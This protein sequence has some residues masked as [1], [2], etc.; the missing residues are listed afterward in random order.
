MG[1]WSASSSYAP[2]DAVSDGNGSAYIALDAV[3]ANGS[4][5][6][7]DPTDWSLLVQGQ[8]SSDVTWSVVA[9]TVQATTTWPGT[10]P[11]S[12]VTGT[13]QIDSNTAISSDGVTSLWVGTGGVTTQGSS[14]TGVGLDALRNDQYGYN[15]TAV[16]FRALGSLTGEPGNYTNNTAVGSNS[17]AYVTTGTYNTGLG[18]ATLLNDSTGGGNTAIGA[19]AMQTYSGTGATDG[20]IAIGYYAGSELT[21]GANNIYLGSQGPASA[22][23]ESGVTRIGTSPT[24]TTTFIAGI[25]GATVGAG[26]QAVYIDS[27]GQLG[28]QVTGGTSSLPPFVAG[29][30][31]NTLVERDGSGSF[32]ANAI[33]LDDTLTFTGTNGSG[34]Y[35]PSGLLLGAYPANNFF[36]GIA[37]GVPPLSGAANDVGIGLGVMHTLTSGNANVIEGAFAGYWMSTGSNNTV[38]GTNALNAAGSG[39]DNVAMGV[40]A[41]A[42]LNGGGSNIAIGYNA[43]TSYGGSESGNILIGAV[44]TGGESNVVRIGTQGTA[45]ATYIGGIYGVPVTGSAVYVTANGQLGIGMAPAGPTGA[46]GA[47]GAGGATGATGTTGVGGATG[48]TGTTG[49]IGITGTTGATGATGATGGVAIPSCSNT[50]NATTIIG[51]STENC[52]GQQDTAL[53]WNALHAA[54]SSSTNNVAVGNGTLAAAVNGNNNTAVG[55]GALTSTAGIGGS[56]TAVGSQ[57]LLLDTMGTGNSAFGFETLGSLNNA[58]GGD[59]NNVAIGFEAGLNLTTGAN[60][61]YLGANAGPIASGSESGTIRIGTEGTQSAAFVA[62]ISGSNVASGASVYVD[63]NGQLGTVL[64]SERFKEDIR[65]IGDDSWVLMDLRPVAFKYKQQYDADGAQQYGLIA[66]EVAKVAPQ[67]V[68]YDENGQPLTV[69]YNL[70]N[71]LLLN[72]VQRLHRE[73]EAQRAQMEL[74]RQDSAA[75]HVHEASLQSEVNDLQGQLRAYGDL[76][77]RIRA[78][79]AGAGKAGGYR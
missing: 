48:A 40:N 37:S 61:I 9:P 26:A 46:T 31:A 59:N 3:P 44:G 72:E 66:E 27:N 14:I 22:G 53:G 71:A 75:L 6:S 77:R 15:D 13:P 10:I 70:V 67:L 20:N 32:S 76:E 73:N 1:V 63:S 4:D 45:S 39:D 23:S 52:T 58:S 56:N 24:S 29:D 2:G 49:V 43:G 19:G 55:A 34:I 33:N 35:D 57:A 36:A 74:A 79:E 5:P 12:Q 11:Y 68:I 47:T 28:T 18:V 7:V 50:G 51:P 64:S 65:D 78:L 21:T 38:V 25:N 54:S 16:G 8:T 41:L 69:R 60:N 30:V 42:Y 62:G 17:L